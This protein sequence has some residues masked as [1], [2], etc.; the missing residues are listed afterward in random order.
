LGEVAITGSNLALSGDEETAGL[1]GGEETA[2]LVSVPMSSECPEVYT[3]HLEI[4]H[5]GFTHLY[6]VEQA[7]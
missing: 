1:S 4:N 6:D 2:D 3:P 5:P 7:L